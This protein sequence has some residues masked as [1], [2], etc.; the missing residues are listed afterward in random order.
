M[1]NV[2][3]FE[4]IFIYIYIG[5]AVR[6]IYVTAS[7]FGRIIRL[8][9]K[10]VY[11][12]FT[13]DFVD[14][15]DFTEVQIDF[16]FNRLLFVRQHIAV[17]HISILFAPYLIAPKE[18]IVKQPQ[19]DVRYIDE[20]KMRAM[21]N[22]NELK[23]YNNALDKFQRQAVVNVMQGLARPMPHIIYGPPGN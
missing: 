4:Y 5:G 3:S 6:V 14:E 2:H 9:D 11:I 22:G 7:Y 1:P 13:K 12:R 15:Y 23:W 19:L 16:Q 20:M 8:D 10:A 17:D 21:L 18:V